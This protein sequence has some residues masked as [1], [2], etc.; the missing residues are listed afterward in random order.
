LKD[1]DPDVRALGIYDRALA[2]VPRRVRFAESAVSLSAERTRHLKAFG[3][4]ELD[5]SIFG[6][7]SKRWDPSSTANVSQDFMVGVAG[8]GLALVPR[9]PGRATVRLD[10][11][12]PLTGTPGFSRTPRFSISIM[13]WLETSRHR[14]KGGL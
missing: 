1:P 8:L 6:A 12:F 10:Y 3:S 14:E 5:A 7:I 2:F 4:Q 13:P 11:G 9:R